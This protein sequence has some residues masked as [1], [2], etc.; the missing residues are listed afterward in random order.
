MEER[1]PQWNWLDRFLYKWRMKLCEASTHRLGWCF[2]CQMTEAAQA[3]GIPSR[4]W[5]FKGGKF[6]QVR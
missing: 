6:I 2:C 1:K 4:Q 5:M 3:A